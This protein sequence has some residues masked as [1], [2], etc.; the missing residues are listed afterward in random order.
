MPL[1]I[2]HNPPRYYPAISGAEF[3]LERM[4]ELLRKVHDVAVHCTNALDFAAFSSL[5]G[6]IVVPRK[7]PERIN[8]VQVFR[9]SI[10]HDPAVIRDER[11]LLAR[12]L[13]GAAPE[14]IQDALDAGPASRGL[15]LALEA[16]NP[17]II[18]ATCFPYQNIL[19]SLH[20]ARSK[21]VPCVVTPFV[22]FENTR[23]QKPSI[24]VLDLF[25]RVLAC[26]QAEKA[27][28]MAHGVHENKIDVI[29]MGV[30]ENRLA[31]APARPF[32][33]ETG[34]DPA[35]HEIVLFSGYKNFEKGAI[36]LLRAVPLVAARFKNLKLVM[37]GPPTKQ[38]NMEMAN[39]G[40]LKH[41]VVNLNPASLSGYY[42]K[43]KLGAFQACHVYA[44]PSRSDAYGIAYLEAF[45]CKKPIIAASIPAMLERFPEGDGCLHVPFDDHQQL[46]DK[47][48]HLLDDKAACRE[49]GTRGHDKIHEE[50]LTWQDVAAR[51]DRIYAD[52]ADRVH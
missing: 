23:Y 36:S 20:V 40:T 17:G 25:D 21:H 22:H 50:G 31:R 26:S 6:K 38:Y 42:D 41:H 35:R 27:Y 48:I 32:I 12:S 24:A 29:T 52:A 45:A 10:D 39:L 43:V 28:L 5:T 47:I 3:Y 30:D 44:M 14:A 51:V 16:S 15:R 18:H 34:V 37:I 2:I 4:S 1:R 8:E 49:L 9:H 11:A 46:A 13:A 7:V 19:V 33:A